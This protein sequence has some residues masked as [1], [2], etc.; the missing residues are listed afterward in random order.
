MEHRIVSEQD[1][2]KEQGSLDVRHVAHLARLHVT[3]AEV[4]TFE[5]QLR[6]VVGYIQKIQALD[7]SGIEPMSHAVSVVNVFRRDE[8]RPSLD[9]DVVLDNAPAV[10]NEQFKVPRIVE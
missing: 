1:Q 4:R 10:V 2:P 9:R 3:D 6:D 8:D 7:V 5:A